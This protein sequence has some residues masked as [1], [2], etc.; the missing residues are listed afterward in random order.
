MVGHT[1]KQ[2]Q[3]RLGHQIR[4]QMMIQYMLNG[5]NKMFTSLRGKALGSIALK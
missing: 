3:K 5:L 1:M 4:L 2:A